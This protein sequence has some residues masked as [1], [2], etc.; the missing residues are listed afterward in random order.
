MLADKEFID[1][2]NS[3]HANTKDTRRGEWI[4][5]HVQY[6][7]RDGIGTFDLKTLELIGFTEWEN[8]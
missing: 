7:G 1:A 3:F 4:K 6:N 5:M 8:I 2:I